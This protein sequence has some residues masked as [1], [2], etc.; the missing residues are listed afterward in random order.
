MAARFAARTAMPIPHAVFVEVVV[1]KTFSRPLRP[2]AD[3]ATA[4]SMPTAADAAS[5][6]A[7]ASRDTALVTAAAA[8][9]TAAAAPRPRPPPLPASSAPIAS[10]RAKELEEVI[11]AD[12]AR[13]RR[14]LCR[15]V[16]RLLGRVVA[17]EACRRRGDAEEGA[18]LRALAP[19]PAVPRRLADVVNGG[20]VRQVAAA[21][22]GGGRLC[23]HTGWVPRVV[24]GR[25]TEEQTTGTPP[26]Q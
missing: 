6:A 17:A 8:A 3:A 23:G 2:I 15:A 5:A 26:C 18:R 7:A 20:G 21:A 19:L 10:T 24:S 14:R 9:A 12:G 13:H 16:G 1:A 11:D 25:P 4:P 22:G